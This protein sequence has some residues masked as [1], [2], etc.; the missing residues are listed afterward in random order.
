MNFS[1]GAGGTV[2]SSKRQRRQRSAVPPTQFPFQ[3]Y[4]HSPAGTDDG[5]FWRFISIRA[6][7]VNFAFPTSTGA[8]NFSTDND[9]IV[10]NRFIKL[11]EG[12]HYCPVFIEININQDS[13]SNQ[14]GS[15]T[16]LYIKVNQNGWTNYPK[17]PGGNSSNG[18]PPSKFYILIGQ[19]STST[20]GVADALLPEDRILTFHT[21][22]VATSNYMLSMEA[23]GQIQCSATGLFTQTRMVLRA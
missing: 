11:A 9:Q 14:L 20:D 16:S 7:S 23:F 15:P 17:E 5:T 2:I 22:Q 8:D 18:N 19:V 12:L 13:S 1:Q 4:Q 21:P 3:I 6:G 10:A